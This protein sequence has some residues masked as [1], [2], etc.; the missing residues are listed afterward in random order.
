MPQAQPEKR[1]FYTI[2]TNLTLAQIQ[3]SFSS[4]DTMSFWELQDFIA[5]LEQSGFSAL[6]HKLYFHSLL[7]TPILLS[8]MI[9]IA[10]IFSLKFSRRSK[11]GIRIFGAVFAGFLLFF[12]TKFT[13]SYGM[14]GNMPIVLA[15]W[16]PA[17]ISIIV[18]AWMLL[19]QEDG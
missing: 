18:G 2:P 13:S 15:A 14:A 9:F 1:E 11:T 12:M 17:I 8:A 7:A 16:S 3:D 4:P 5:V 6:R 19:H 10:A